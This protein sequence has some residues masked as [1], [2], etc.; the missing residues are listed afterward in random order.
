MPRPTRLRFFLE[1]A[2]GLIVLSSIV[3]FLDLHQVAHPV[4]HSA[5]RRS[6]G[7]LDRMLAMAQAQALHRLAVLVDRA[8]QALHQG[9]LDLLAG[10]RLLGGHFSNPQTA[11][12]ST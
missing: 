2:A 10:T 11:S 5:D 4:D 3:L 6:V 12:S 9:H 7:D 1:P 8:A